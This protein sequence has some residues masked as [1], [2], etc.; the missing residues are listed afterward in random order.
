VDLSIAP[1]G[2]K[3]RQRTFVTAMEKQVQ[4]RSFAAAAF[5]AHPLP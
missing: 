3:K 2:V 4:Y 5:C 1:H